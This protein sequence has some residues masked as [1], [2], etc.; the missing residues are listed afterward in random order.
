[1]SLENL[2]TDAQA[3]GLNRETIGYLSNLHE[4]AVSF[5]TY[6][7]WDR[8]YDAVSTLVSCTPLESP[9]FQFYLNMMQAIQNHK[10]ASH[11]QT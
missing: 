11:E 8:F 3:V 9:A 6:S 10:G 4:L 2:K 1:M 7:M 5:N